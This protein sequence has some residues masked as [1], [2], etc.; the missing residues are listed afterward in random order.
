[1][2]R[3]GSSS[4][5]IAACSAHEAIEV[6]GST[7]RLCGST[8]VGDARRRR[9]RRGR[10]APRRRPPAPR[11]A[12]GRGGAERCS[13]PCRRRRRSRSR[14]AASGAAR[15]RVG[16]RGNGSRG[17]SPRARSGHAALVRRAVY[18]LV[19]CDHPACEMRSRARRSSRRSGRRW[20]FASRSRRRTP[21]C[22]S[23][24]RDTAGS[25][26]RRR[27]RSRQNARRP[28]GGA[29]IPFSWSRPTTSGPR[30]VDEHGLRHAAEAA[31]RPE[32]PFA[33][34]VL[35]LA[36]ER[37]H[38][39][40]T[41]E[42][43]HGD[44]EENASRRRRQS[45]RTSRRSR[46]ASGAR[47]PSR[48]A[49]SPARLRDAHDG[50]RDGPLHRT[51]TRRDALLG[52]QLRHHHRVALRS[53]IEQLDRRSSCATVETARARSLLLAGLGAAP[54][55]ALHRH[56]G[57]A[58]HSSD[59]PEPPTKP[60]Q[61]T[62]HA[63]RLGIDHRH[64]HDRAEC[65]T[66]VTSSFRHFLPSLG[67]GRGTSFS[68][69]SGSVYV[70]L[71]RRDAPSKAPPGRRCLTRTAAPCRLVREL[72]LLSLGRNLPLHSSSRPRNYP[73]VG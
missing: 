4:T 38:E 52:Q 42:A 47:A 36:Q 55:V 7:T 9:R 54:E 41:R 25:T 67:C 29:A 34:V 46:S 8:S 71:D 73:C 51:D 32:Q 60:P 43:E 28:G 57:D 19:G 15:A 59:A 35:P 20:R 53:S 70:S 64:L 56:E 18:A 65:Q 39:D 6:A 40:P 3:E 48:S 16:S 17:R 5:A 68:V 30:V 72:A 50:A 10:C 26:R 44:E 27:P 14:R 23:S 1:M 2:A 12:L 22:P 69:V 11:R 33:P 37:L 49:P 62:H 21:S 66:T 63:Y 24:G 45:R 31:E 13:G 58:N 61:L